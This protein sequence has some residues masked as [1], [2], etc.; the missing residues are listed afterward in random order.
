M[1]KTFDAVA[2]MRK[3]RMEI[4]EEDQGLSW[5]EKHKKTRELLE[6]DPLWQRLKSRLIEP[7]SAAVGAVRENREEYGK[8]KDD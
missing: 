4:D 1:K 8:K 5:S 6:N 3:R 7:T 2:W